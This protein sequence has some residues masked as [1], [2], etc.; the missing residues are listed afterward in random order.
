MTSEMAIAK[1]VKI[2]LILFCVAI[3]GYSAIDTSSGQ[4]YNI[5]VGT[6]MPLSIVWPFEVAVVGDLGEKGLRI[7]PKIGRG[8]R[9]EAGGEATYRFY[10]PQNGKYHI[11]AYALWF[12]ECANAVFARI[13]DL[14]KAIVGNDPVYNRWHW[15]R[16]FD[17]CLE[18]G[19]HTLVLSNHS[20]HICLQKVL[21]T[22]SGYITPE[23][24][25]LVFSDIFYD[26]FDGCDRGNFAS[27]Q[28]ISG[29][30]SV[31]NP[32]ERM[33]FVENALVG[34]SDDSSF[35]IHKGD[36]WAHYSLNMA[37]RSVVPESNDGSVS[38]CFG[39][40]DAIHYLQL[41][42][43]HVQGTDRVRMELA[44]KDAEAMEVLAN[45]EVTWAADVW[46][47]LELSLNPGRIVV[48]VDNAEPIAT[49]VS[50][51]VTGGIGLRLEGKV[52]A[53]FDDIHVRQI[54]HGAI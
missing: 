17:V 50:C 3:Y 27:W 20:D 29:D 14:D 47:Q 16:G 42:W 40:K 33:C 36:D 35:I 46:H 13:D 1:F 26:G 28:V 8:W 37:V 7:G 15:V 6:S 21:F 34:K 4:T 54:S 25:S 12:D 11:W 32:V 43:R 22:N 31:Q 52:A 39:V 10:I 49:P 5:S 45:F 44:R 51:E 30:W 23:D 9:G 53:Y 2:L 41:T 24:C 48:R 18:K 19:T 38:V